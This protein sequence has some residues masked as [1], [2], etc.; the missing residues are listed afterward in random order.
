MRAVSFDGFSCLQSLVLNPANLCWLPVSGWHRTG[1][2]ELV[3]VEGFD[4]MTEGP[5]ALASGVI[6]CK[7]KM[8]LGL[9]LKCQKLVDEM[10]PS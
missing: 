5:C 8:I 9:S 3:P 4:K 1:P 10:L 6:S 7:I 2:T